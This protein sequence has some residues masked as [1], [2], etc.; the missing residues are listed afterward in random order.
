[1]NCLITRT[2]WLILNGC[3]L[4]PRCTFVEKR[5]F[6]SIMIKVYVVVCATFLNLLMTV[7]NSE[8]WTN[9]LGTRPKNTTTKKSPSQEDWN[10]NNRKSRLLWV[11]IFFGLFKRHRNILKFHSG[12]R[13]LIWDQ[14]YYKFVKMFSD[15]FVDHQEPSIFR[16]FLNGIICPANYSLI[17][18]F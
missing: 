3:F 12:F 4:L 15:F 11:F 9:R 8:K 16:Y 5:V 2:F 17:K 7:S 6:E 10:Q 1:M 14:F 13:S 18:M